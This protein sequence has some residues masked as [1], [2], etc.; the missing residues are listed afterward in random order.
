MQAGFGMV[1]T[2]FEGRF[3]FDHLPAAAY[4]LSVEVAG[5]E[6]LV[7]D[8]DLRTRPGPL[9][10]RL[11]AARPLV[12][13][14]AGLSEAAVGTKFKWMIQ[15]SSTPFSQSG[16]AV[17]DA[18][19]E[20]RVDSPPNGEY[21]LLVFESGPLPRFEQGFRVGAGDPLPIVLRVPGGARVTGTLRS[22]DGQPLGGVR[23]RIGDAEPVLTDGEGKFAFPRVGNGLQAAWIHLDDG[24]LR[25]GTV[26]VSGSASLDVRLPGTAELTATLV[27]S[28][29][30]ALYPAGGKDPRSDR[31]GMVASARPDAKGRIRVPYLAAGSYWL[32]AYGRDANDEDR[33]FDLA[34]GQVL[35][36]GEVRLVPCV[37]M[38]VRVSV[39]LGAQRPALIVA[40]PVNESG[41]PLIGKFGRI[42][43]DGEGR[44]WLKG[45]PAGEYRL[46]FAANGF[47][48]TPPT[49]V[50]VREGAPLP[51]SIE[52]RKP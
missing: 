5:H 20:V 27:G 13:R 29:I 22:F 17:L 14:F 3:V 12:L 34:H 32:F 42:E 48:Q 40:Q 43:F 8:L 23:V 30:A 11:V 36:L 15:G 45:L 31:S 18:T 26:D 10:L 28:P 2:D 39:P 7:R 4:W 25:I 24:E 38:E 52:L 9:D 21:R 51:I 16:K 50:T 46:V 41:G 37:V 44:G 1:R 6:T 35:D 33:K 49:P 47:E 19:G